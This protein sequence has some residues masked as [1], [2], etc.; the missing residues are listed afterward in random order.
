MDPA[1]L[2]LAAPTD[3][4]IK[5]Q[6]LAALAAGAPLKTTARQFGVSHQTLRNWKDAAGL[7]PVLTESDRA[8]VSAALDRHICKILATLDQQLDRA[9]ALDWFSNPEG[10]DAF[11]K[12][13]HTLQNGA[14]RIVAA[15]QVEAVE[16][17]QPIPIRRAI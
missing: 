6:A 16:D 7:E 15:Q 13:W 12:L 14:A 17:E 1:G 8:N 3:P 10:T 2:L 5:A 9:A 11:I 4:G